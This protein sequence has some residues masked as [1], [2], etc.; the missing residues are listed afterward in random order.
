MGLGDMTVNS[1]LDQPFNAE[2]ELIDVGNTPLT[3]IK[4]NLASVEDYEKVG[5]EQAY[6][7]SYLS[8]NI[9]KNAK[10]KPVIK[11][12]SI[13]RISEPY[14]QLL[15]DLAWANGQVYRS[16]TIL[17]DPPNYK[18]G[19]VKKQLRNIVK[20]QSEIEQRAN[21]ENSMQ[22]TAN[23]DVERPSVPAVID[24]RGVTTYG[25]TVANE[26]IWQIAQ[27]YKTENIILQQMILAIVGSNPQAF[28]EGNLNGLKEGS[29]LLIP[30]NK[31]ASRVPLAL[32]KL[33][34]IAHD[35]A[36][37]SRQAIEHALLPPYINSTAPPA[38]NEQ[39]RGPLGYSL[40]Q[41]IIPALS[42]SSNVESVDKESS[43]LLPLASSL[44]TIGKNS[45]SANNPQIQSQYPLSSQANIKAGLGI[46]T[47]A[48]ASAHEA[49]T[50][51]IEQLHSLQTENKGLQQQSVKRE[52][53]IDKLREQM[54]L[55]LTSQGLA[56]QASQQRPGEEKGGI[57]LL[58][59]FLLGLGVGGGL[60]YWWLWVRFQLEKQHPPA[61]DSNER[62][63]QI[64]EP[65]FFK[66][67]P[68]Q[69]DIST[70]AVFEEIPSVDPLEKEH[71]GL[72]KVA[73]EDEK[74]ISTLIDL[75]DKPTAEAGL[76]ELESAGSL[77]LDVEKPG[78]AVAGLEEKTTSEVGSLA[79]GLAGAL[80]IEDEKPSSAA[81]DLEEKFKAETDSIEHEAINALP[82][83]E[84]NP[85][86]DPI[87]LELI[88]EP[89]VLKKQETLEDNSIE[90]LP[91]LSHDNEEP[92]V[93]SSPYH[94]VNAA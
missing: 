94:R 86:S 31:I 36:W 74:S 5:L 12:R 39:E 8:F 32:A 23:S 17:L 26:T 7:L 55:L 16:Y 25:P 70:P 81:V 59:L 42:T 34:V 4:A 41:S 27:R 38:V 44:L 68:G 24:H 79:L 35:T 61:Q 88:P 48:I 77:S 6:A 29:R 18:L 21:H 22:R 76:L 2:I 72:A 30:A 28:T 37:Q 53:E 83:E 33:E 11:V 10:G 85:S 14:V 56:G 1:S 47:V 54:R 66:D 57:S 50:L 65:A 84:G 15:V 93:V 67:L 20:R 19:L 3:G 92:P 45:A 71:E 49:N 73:I 62:P 91:E 60:V 52:Q 13:E 69:N 89:L 78:P 87:D 9:E 80:S 82:I 51:L 75:D 58:I 40:S 43:R 90:F 46:S 63:F 64:T